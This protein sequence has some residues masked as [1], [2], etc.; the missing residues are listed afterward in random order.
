MG[1]N[2]YGKMLTH[3]RSELRVMVLL[4]DSYGAGTNYPN[5][6]KQ[7][8][9]EDFNK[10]LKHGE[11]YLPN[12]VHIND[13]NTEL[14]KLLPSSSEEFSHGG[15]VWPSVEHF[16]Q[17]RKFKHLDRFLI[18]QSVTDLRKIVYDDK[19]LKRLPR[20]SFG[21]EKIS[22]MY[23]GLKMKLNAHPETKLRLLGTKNAYLLYSNQ[24]E[25]FWG[26][27]KTEGGG[28]YLGKILMLLR[29]EF[30]FEERKL[31]TNIYPSLKFPFRNNIQFPKEY[32][33]C[34]LLK[35]LLTNSKQ[36]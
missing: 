6:N 31:D 29:K 17:S 8:L 23:A 35:S 36:L 18:T 32:F 34:L 5:L 13:E 7:N 14:V 3:I 19:L 22:I 15:H 30:R 21:E 28:N 1:N 9:D 25:M 33:D 27:G 2:L 4:E 16:Y 12:T 26:C 24:E 10:S 11:V 20:R